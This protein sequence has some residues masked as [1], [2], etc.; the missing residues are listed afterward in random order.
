MFVDR[1]G[2]ML[3]LVP[4]TDEPAGPGYDDIPT[5]CLQPKEPTS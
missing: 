2:W 1:M 4:G 5:Y 3:C